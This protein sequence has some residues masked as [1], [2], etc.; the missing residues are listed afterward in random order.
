MPNNF[1]RGIRD[2]TLI[3]FRS[4]RPEQRKLN[5]CLGVRCCHVIHSC[6]DEAFR[7]TQDKLLSTREALEFH[8]ASILTS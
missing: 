7:M 6:E 3:S 1:F 8:G 2:Y 5:S 4:N